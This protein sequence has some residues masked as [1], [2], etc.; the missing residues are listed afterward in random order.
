MGP[1]FPYQDGLCV[2]QT[3][4]FSCPLFP[5]VYVS[6]HER[7][8]HLYVLGITGK[9][10]SKFLEGLILQDILAGRGCGVID[11]HSD[12][13]RTIFGHLVTCGYVQNAAHHNP[14]VY[15]DINK[16]DT[17]PSFNVL[18]VQGEPYA[19]AQLVIEAFRRTWPDPLKE[20]P[21]FS[22]IMLA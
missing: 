1:L 6:A 9:G 21:Q 3:G 22:N 5:H 13:A 14:I 15:L 20:A 10:K 2:G 19:I 4:A 11:P 16:P 18:A 7:E 8:K 17:I 12:L